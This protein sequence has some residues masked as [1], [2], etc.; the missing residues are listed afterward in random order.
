MTTGAHDPSH[1]RESSTALGSFTV[2]SDEAGLRLDA[3]LRRRLP[4]LSRRALQAAIR[5]GHVRVGGKRVAKAHALAEGERVEVRL[6]A[7]MAP[8]PDPSLPLDVVFEDP[9]LLVVNKPAGMP[10]QPLRP[11]EP[12]TLASAALARYPEL[13]RVGD[14]PREAGLVHRLDVD[15]SGLVMFARDAQTHH[16]LRRLLAERAVEKTYV[17]R[18]APRADAAP[19]APGLYDA[20]AEADRGPRVQVRKEG[21]GRPIETRVDAVE[22][23][24]DGTVVVRVAVHFACRHQV[25]AH[26]AML[27]Y[28]LVGDTIYGRPF[29][30]DGHLL[31]AET[32]LFVHPVTGSPIRATIQPPGNFFSS[33]KKTPR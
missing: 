6:P 24:T 11:G 33:L 12:G 30:H 17:A 28:P 10:C 22:P 3:V 4:A 7:S 5:E 9:H 19:L 29:G 13:A 27:G 32:I 23:L 26:L 14:D 20:R 18:C 1:S 25:R 15:T 31:H 16:G 21:Q 8:N 2:G